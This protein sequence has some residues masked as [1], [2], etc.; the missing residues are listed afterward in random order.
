MWE[1]LRK[2]HQKTPVRWF[3]P[4]KTASRVVAPPLPLENGSVW[5]CVQFK[6]ILV[7][8]LFTGKAS[9]GRAPSQLRSAILARLN[10]EFSLSCVKTVYIRA[11]ESLC[12]RPVPPLGEQVCIFTHTESQVARTRSCT[13]NV[14]NPQSAG[15]FS[16]PT[17]RFHVIPYFTPWCESC[18]FSGAR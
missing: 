6:L 17:T 14:G 11:L 9:R 10:A 1:S 12:L 16:L 2:T 4:P 8:P 7:R 5:V 18:S 15:A 3:I 13:S